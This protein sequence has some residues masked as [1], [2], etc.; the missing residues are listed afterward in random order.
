MYQDTH[1]NDIL[2]RS[3]PK[4]PLQLALMP[5]DGYASVTLDVAERLAE[6]MADINAQ[7]IPVWL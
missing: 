4:P 3:G 5:K 1:I 6:R 2:K 7:G